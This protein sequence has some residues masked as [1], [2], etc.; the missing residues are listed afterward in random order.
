MNFQEKKILYKVRTH[1]L[2]MLEARKVVLPQ[3]LLTVTFE[4]FAVAFEERN[5][6]IFLQD[7]RSGEKIYIFFQIDD[8]F[9]KNDMKTLVERIFRTYADDGIHMILMLKDEENTTLAKERSKILY[10]NVE[11]FHQKM[12]TINITRHRFVPQHIILSPE[13]EAQVLEKYQ[14][15]KSKFPVI[16]ATDAQA[17]YYGMKPDQMCKIVRIDP[18]VGYSIAYRVVR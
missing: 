10:R 14:T 8:S 11:I 6:D 4:Q 13:E 5:I 17:R 1:T 12:F 16:P 2:E 3:E 9:G 7:E 15:P 18:E